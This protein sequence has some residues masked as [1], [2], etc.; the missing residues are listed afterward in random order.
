MPLV[1]VVFLNF[2]DLSVCY[3]IARLRIMIADHT[4][5]AR[6]R[7]LGYWTYSGIS[8]CINVGGINGV[9]LQRVR[10]MERSGGPGPG[11]GPPLFDWAP[12]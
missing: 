9:P 7:G 4:L 5:G 1:Q 11:P 2:P 10:S 12:L 8:L 3:L 6:A